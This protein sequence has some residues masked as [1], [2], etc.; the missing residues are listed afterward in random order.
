[1]KINIEHMIDD[2]NMDQI[3]HLFINPKQIFPYQ[4]FILT[5]NYVNIDTENHKTDIALYIFPE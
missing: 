5:F 2:I 4:N 1:M 3:I